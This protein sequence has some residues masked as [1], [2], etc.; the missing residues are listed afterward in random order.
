MPYLYNAADLFC[1]FSEREGCPNV[2]MEAIACGLPSVVCGDWADREMIPTDDIGYIAG[3]REKSELEKVIRR[4]LESRW[5]RE[6]IRN[7]SLENS[8]KKV[9]EKTLELY[10]GM[11]G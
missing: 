3:S 10:Q 9:A 8:W 6:K 2:L 7:F 5:D 1:L 4:A 11:A